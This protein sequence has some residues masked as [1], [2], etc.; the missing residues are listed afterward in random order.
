[1]LTSCVFLF[2]LLLANI[3]RNPL[4]PFLRSVVSH[5]LIKGIPRS[6]EDIHVP[7]QLVP[8]TPVSMA[9]RKGSHADCKPTPAVASPWSSI[10][11]R[12]RLGTEHDS[13][14]VD[15]GGGGGGGG[16]AGDKVDGNAIHGEEINGGS[17]NGRKDVNKDYSDEGNRALTAGNRGGKSTA[18]VDACAAPAC[19]GGERGDDLAGLDSST[20]SLDLKAPARERG[21]ITDALAWGVSSVA[22]GI[23]LGITGV[24]SASGSAA[25]MTG[26]TIGSAGQAV[27]TVLQTRAEAEAAAEAVR[28]AGLVDVAPADQLKECNDI[29]LTVLRCALAREGGLDEAKVLVTKMVKMRAILAMEA[30]EMSA[31]RNIMEIERREAELFPDEKLIHPRAEVSLGN[32]G[33]SNE[34]CKHGLLHKT[35]SI[36]GEAI[37]TRIRHAQLPPSLDLFALQDFDNATIDVGLVATAEGA[38]LH[39]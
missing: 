12:S 34:M 2:Y 20:L 37:E 9:P 24:V 14:S 7:Q 13:G 17:T 26:N 6:P 16:G 3:R 33:F 1:M 15:G 11:T 21:A 27:R 38:T 23:I 19:C 25:K 5:A 29:E 28:L 32:D 22:D 30:E 18:N 31:H 10:D 8:M 35:T 4:S 36:E 39:G